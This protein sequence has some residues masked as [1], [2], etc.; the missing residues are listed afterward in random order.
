MTGD[1]LPNTA[2][3]D[4]FDPFQGGE[5]EAVVPTTEPQREVWLA[6]KT[7]PDASLAYNESVTLRLR[8]RVDADA[9]V[10]ALQQL[11]AAHDALRATISPDGMNLCISRDLALDCVRTDLSAL[12]EL[13][14]AEALAYARRRHVLEPF[15]LEIGITS[16]AT[17][18]RFPS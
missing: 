1:P 5:L 18:G 16:S 8:G 3:S 7:Q 17:G 4:D 10:L 12:A 11:V 9:L 13:D 6:S 14:R 2:G 15:D